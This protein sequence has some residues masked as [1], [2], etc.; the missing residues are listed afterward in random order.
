MSHGG[1]R[2]IR[3][4]LVAVVVVG[5]CSSTRANPESAPAATRAYMALV[6][7]HNWAQVWKNLVPQQ[8]AL[9]TRDRFVACS[10]RLDPGLTFQIDKLLS[11]RPG[12]ILIPG[13]KL[14]VPSIAVTYQITAGTA[15]RVVVATEHAF[16]VNGEWR[17]TMSAQQAQAFQ[18][19]RCPP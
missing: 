6:N 17:F 15:H 2:L 12:T 4:G 8:Q 18:V 7:Q 13:T 19:G 1:L 5:A 14:T 16:R 11:T 9:V 10:Q 3:C